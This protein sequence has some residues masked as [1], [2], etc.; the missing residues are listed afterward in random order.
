M[1]TVDCVCRSIRP[2]L[3]AA[4]LFVL[5]AP[6]ASAASTIKLTSQ[7]TD[8]T[9][10]LGAG[11]ADV[12]TALDGLLNNE[13]VQLWVV[14]VQTTGSTTAPAAAQQTFEGNGFGGNDMVLLI[15][16]GDHRYGWWEVQATGLPGSTIDDLLSSRMEPP[17]GS[18]YYAN[19]IVDF[20]TALGHQIDAARNPVAKPTVAGAGGQPAGGQPASGNTNSVDT[21]GL[22]TVLWTLIAIIVITGGL[23][24]LALWFGSWHRSRLSAEERDKQTGDLARQANKMLVDTDNS[25]RD[26]VQ[27]V[28][29]AQAEFDDSDVKP[30]QDAVNAAQD[31]LKQ[32]FA[33][34]HQLD[35]STPEDLPTKQKM[36]GDIIAHCQAAL[37]GV[38]E[39]AKRLTAL[40]DL[41]KTAPD[42]LA[43]LPKAIDALKARLPEVQ[44]AT[45]ALCA[46]QPSSWASVKGNAEEADKR[47]HFA[48]AQIEA[49]KA[50]LAATPPDKPA[51]AHAARAAQEAVA[52]ANG[53]L[54]AVVQLAAAMDQA[55][56]QIKDEWAAAMADVA[57][58][59]AAVQASAAS[60]RNDSTAANLARA[61]AQLK[62]AG[63]GPNA[64]TPDPIAALKAVQA[65]HAS[66][67]QV[68][69]DI[70][71]ASS[72]QARN[73]AAFQTARASAA[74]SV[75]QAQAFIGARSNGVGASARAR[76]AEAQRHMAQADALAATDPATA[77]N[78]ANVATNLANSA[79]TLAS[80]NFVDYE[81][82]GQPPGGGMGGGYG[83]GSGIGG[84]IIGGIIGGMMGGGVRRGGGFGGTPWGSGGG[85]TGGGGGLGGGGGFGGFGGGFGGGHGG[86]G[87]FGGGGGGGGGHGGGGGW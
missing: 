8:Q 23:V 42:A 28:G 1:R 24:L 13:N 4:G 30:Y 79:Y 50:A 36:Y 33:I 73:Q 56:G 27:E 70:R 20:V 60:L 77:A 17:F 31:E 2:F 37:A 54:D 58:A 14:L 26:A 9:G 55:R 78:E 45:K 51:A 5:L 3:L 22:S 21:S 49:G 61:E 80:G 82:G 16:V 67:D 47:G 25:L 53:L 46:Y 83:G 59:R 65:A 84:A 35:D 11:K 39:Q 76:L 64:A 18:G 75:D 15:A 85:W 68:L 43:A 10:V 29:F 57:A 12:Q 87:S 38:D 63:T 62:S 86:G 71:D 48:E 72:Q 34:R 52:Q 81:R 66:A 32:A 69:T 40:R 74:A 19:G 7:I 44:A 6:A 41:E